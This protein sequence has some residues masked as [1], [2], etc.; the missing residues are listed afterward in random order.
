MTHPQSWIIIQID[1]FDNGEHLFEMHARESWCV[2][3]HLHRVSNVAQVSF[4]RGGQAAKRQI[5][6]EIMR[7]HTWWND[8]FTGI[9]AAQQVCTLLQVC[10]TANVL[11]A[12]V[13]EPTA[14]GTTTDFHVNCFGEGRKREKY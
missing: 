9:P 13:L 5:A 14:I 12:I 2:Q 8:R 3:F 4:E 7:S 11:F 10:F 6:M 1:R